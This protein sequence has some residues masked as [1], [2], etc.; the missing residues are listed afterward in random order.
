MSNFYK[1]INEKNEERKLSKSDVSLEMLQAVADLFKEVGIE[2]VDKKLG[3]TFDNFVAGFE[4]ELE[5]GD[6]D[7]ETDT[8]PDVHGHDDPVALA[9][10]TMAHHKEDKDY[11]PKLKKAMP[12]G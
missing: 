7:K 1:L 6:K 2:M 9:K 4:A 10:I 5:H 11:Y 8:I 12:N 3:F